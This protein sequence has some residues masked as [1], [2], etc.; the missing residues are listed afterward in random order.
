MKATE[1]SQT[2]ILATKLSVSWVRRTIIGNPEAS[3][4]NIQ[5]E[6]V[7]RFWKHQ[8]QQKDK[9]ILVRFFHLKKKRKMHLAHS[10]VLDKNSVTQN[11]KFKKV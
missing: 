8:K 10:N 6:G 2:S 5:K 9:Q 3:R 7:L 11:N 1:L 4:R